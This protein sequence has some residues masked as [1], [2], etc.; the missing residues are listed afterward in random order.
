MGQF[1]SMEKYTYVA[2]ADDATNDYVKIPITVANLE[3][4][5]PTG[6]IA[7]I[8]A[9]TTGVVNSAG[10]AITYA[11]GVVKVVATA[12]TAGDVVTLIVFD[13]N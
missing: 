2:V 9:A 5:A 11:D 12:I 13:A 10:L 8:R 3:S 4:G 6:M 7:Q 1:V